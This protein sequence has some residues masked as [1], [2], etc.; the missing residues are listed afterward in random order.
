[1]KKS[2]QYQW[3]ILGRNT[4]AQGPYEANKSEL[5]NIY[6]ILGKLLLSQ[7]MLD[8]SALNIIKT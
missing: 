4:R 8:K 2:Y 1:M 5:M 6:G 7:I 3:A